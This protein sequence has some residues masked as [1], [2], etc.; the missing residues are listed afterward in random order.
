M[1]KRVAFP[2]AVCLVALATLSACGGSD[3]AALTIPAAPAGTGKTDSAPVSDEAA[4]LPYVDY[5][6]TNQRGDARY[7]PMPAGQSAGLIT[8]LP[9]AA[10]VVRSIVEQADRV[11]RAFVAGGGS[12][13]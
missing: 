1:S 9:S 4:V 13:A 5:A 11:V 10:E 8:D 2:F 7:Y 6:F 3:D 12:A